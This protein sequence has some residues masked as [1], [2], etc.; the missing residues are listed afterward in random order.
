MR[1]MAAKRRR[2]PLIQQLRRGSRG[3]RGKSSLWR[4]AKGG[5]RIRLLTLPRG[6][7]TNRANAR[8]FRAEV[9]AGRPLYSG[10]SQKAC[11]GRG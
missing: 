3:K 9:K 5:K 7:H 1:I 11:A 2:C 8:R 10:N 6:N 4:A